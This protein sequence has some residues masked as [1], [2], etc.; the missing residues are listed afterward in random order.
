MGRGFFNKGA[1]GMDAAVSSAGR[2]IYEAG[3]FTITE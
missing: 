1:P 2:W 3:G